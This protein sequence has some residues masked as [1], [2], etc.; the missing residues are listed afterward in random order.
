MSETVEAIPQSR[1]QF[2]SLLTTGA[3]T[4]ATVG[5]LYPVIAYFIPPSDGDG[6]GGIAARD[7]AGKDFSVTELLAK[8]PAGG[9]VLS[10]G[11]SLAAGN[12]TYIVIDENKQVAKY[13]LNAVCPHLGCVVPWDTGLGKFK[14]PCH[15]S[16]YATDGGLLNGPSP[17]PMPLVKAEVK[18]DKVLFTPWTEN[19]FRKTELYSNPE[20]WWV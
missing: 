16:A 4:G 11:L 14:C 13:G 18:D 2:L 5:A 15:G 20:P 8:E 9:R 10:Q 12:A 17:Y 3:I 19:D 6:T 1:R 7:R